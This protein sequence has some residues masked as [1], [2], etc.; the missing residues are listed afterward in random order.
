[1]ILPTYNERENLPLITYMLVKTFEKH[2]INYEI[3]VVDDSSKDG[4]YAV[5]EK[6]QKIYLESIGRLKSEHQ[7]IDGSPLILH[8]FWV[9]V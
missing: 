6:L 9:K 5:G 3:I 4:T 7:R 1:M 2:Q 8:H